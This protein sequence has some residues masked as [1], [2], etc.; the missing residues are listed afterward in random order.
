MEV[1]LKVIKSKKDIEFNKDILIQSLLL[2]YC[3]QNSATNYDFICNELHKV[4]LIKTI[5]NN[6]E[7]TNIRQKYLELL[8]SII[9]KSPLKT[10]IS[11]QRYQKEFIEIDKIGYGGFGG[12]YECIN[13]IDQNKYAIKKIPLKNMDIKILRE[14]YFMSRLNHNNIIRYYSSWIDY[15]NANEFDDEFDDESTSEI[16]NNCQTLKLFIQMEMCDISLKEFMKTNNNINLRKTIFRQVLE[17]VKYLHQNNIIHRDL[18]P[19]NILIK[20]NDNT[21]KIADFG[22]ARTQNDNISN[23]LILFKDAQLLNKYLTTNIGTSIYASPEQLSSTNYNEKTD[24]F[25]L[26]I[27]YFEL[28]NNF[29]TTMEKI[30]AIKDLKNN[31]IKI[32]NNELKLID[33][34]ISGDPDKRPNIDTVILVFNKLNKNIL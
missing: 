30:V 17:G 11:Q 3:Q 24:I 26:G 5:C 19:D 10:E 21:V 22:L 6:E 1:T 25:S 4:G 9:D 31:K 13:K 28:L 23:D 8:D 32:T 33:F 14:S 34:M 12:V 2:F 18:K 15:D 20:L 27:I 16:V 7:K 29:T